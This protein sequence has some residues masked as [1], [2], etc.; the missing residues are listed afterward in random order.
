MFKNCD[1]NLT[2]AP[3]K[4]SQALSHQLPHHYGVPTEDVLQVA[5]HNRA[6]DSPARGSFPGIPK[7]TMMAQFCEATAL[8][9]NSFH[10]FHIST[11]QRIDSRLQNHGHCPTTAPMQRQGT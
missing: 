3:S 10:L 2:M 1:L 4:N 9:R 6:T 7:I 8:S 5:C 11:Q